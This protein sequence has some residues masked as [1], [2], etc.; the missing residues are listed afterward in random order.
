MVLIAYN[1]NLD[2]KWDGQFFCGCR[3]FTCCLSNEDSIN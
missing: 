3:K 2:Y 1:M